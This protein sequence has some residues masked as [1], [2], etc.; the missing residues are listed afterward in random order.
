MTEDRVLGRTGLRVSQSEE[1]VG[2]A[3]AKSGKRYQVTLCALNDLVRQGKVRYIGSSTFP[4]H[5]IVEAQWASDRRGLERFVC[6][7]PR[8]SPLVR[9]IEAGVL[10]VA[11]KYGMGVIVWTPLAGG[12][13]S[14]RWSR[15]A[16]T[17]SPQVISVRIGRAGLSGCRTATT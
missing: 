10:P 14:G 8:Y 5:Q 1:F 2:Q 11:E 4:A 17:S 9:G 12:W 15:I 6:E 13:L 16:G 3:L 7:Q